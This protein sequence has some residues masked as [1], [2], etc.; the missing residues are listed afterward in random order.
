M[1]SN[2]FSDKKQESDKFGQKYYT[3]FIP[4]DQINPY[5][6]ILTNSRVLYSKQ[7]TKNSNDSSNNILLKKYQGRTDGI[8]EL[9]EDIESVN[10]GILGENKQEGLTLKS[11]FL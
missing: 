6:S 11:I 4:S 3:S 8:C 2:V 1:V 7:S 5:A 9:E 10:F